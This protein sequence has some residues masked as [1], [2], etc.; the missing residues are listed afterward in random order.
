M[1]I[2]VSAYI[3]YIYT[4]TQHTLAYI[5]L[6][7]QY[8]Y[9]YTYIYNKI[10]YINT[11]TYTQIRFSPSIE[12]PAARGV[13]VHSRGLEIFGGRGIWYWRRRGSNTTCCIF[14]NIFSNALVLAA[15]GEQYT[16]LWYTSR[17]STVLVVKDQQ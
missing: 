5:Y 6:Y 7:M 12:P 4:H 8:L 2:C 1:Y 10:I 14:L 11:H 16:V 3:V 15:A 9:A 17:I 13:P